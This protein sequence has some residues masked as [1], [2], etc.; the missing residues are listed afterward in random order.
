[1]MTAVGEDLRGQLV[2][3]LG[4]VV[5]T[6][7]VQH[8]PIRDVEA[9]VL[10]QVLDLTHDVAQVPAA[11]EVVGQ[12]EVQRDDLAAVARDREAAPGP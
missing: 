3:P 1:M 8:D 7:H 6:R 2:E 9:G 4:Q 11:Q 10:P 5:D 12:G